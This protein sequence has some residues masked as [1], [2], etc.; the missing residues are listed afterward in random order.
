VGAKYFVVGKLLVGN[1]TFIRIFLALDNYKVQYGIFLKVKK[2]I[3]SLK[4]LK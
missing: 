4:E 3:K 2:N 1:E